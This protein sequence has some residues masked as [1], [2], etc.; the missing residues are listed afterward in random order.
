MDPAC[1]SSILNASENGDIDIVKLL[2]STGA[3]I[4]DKDNDNRS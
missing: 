1:W 4:H 2:L 3:N